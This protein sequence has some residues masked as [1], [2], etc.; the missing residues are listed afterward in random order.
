VRQNKYTSFSGTPAD[1]SRTNGF[2]RKPEQQIAQK[3]LE[4]PIMRHW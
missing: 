2:D 4:N 1:E 3:M